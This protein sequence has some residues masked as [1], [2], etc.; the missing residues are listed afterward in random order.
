MASDQLIIPLFNFDREDSS[1][2]NMGTAQI[3]ETVQV[4]GHQANANDPPSKFSVII[5]QEDTEKPR[6]T[7]DRVLMVFKLFKDQVALSRVIIKNNQVIDYLRHY[8]FYTFAKSKR[9]FFLKKEEEENF[10]AFWEE[11]IDLPSKLFP[12]FKFHLADYQPYAIEQIVD[13]VLCLEYLLVPDSRRGEIA[14][15]FRIGGTVIIGEG[16]TPEEKRDIYKGLK[17][18]YNMRS[19]IV[20]GKEDE[21]KKVYK[22]E[23]IDDDFIAPIR[24]YARDAIVYF[25]RHNCLGKNDPRGKLIRE[26]TLSTIAGDQNE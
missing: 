3:V 11:F 24:R 14:Y 26:K 25:H 2:L 8:E 15:K 10:V 5:S 17:R 23:S 20:H 12:V 6:R 19:A 18:A 1:T 16:K 13:Y 9:P 21:L 22:S 7:L 4:L